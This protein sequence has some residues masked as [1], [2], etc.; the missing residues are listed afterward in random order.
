MVMMVCTKMVIFWIIILVDWW[1]I[2]H[3]GRQNKIINLENIIFSN[4]QSAEH[5]NDD[6]CHRVLS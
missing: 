6:S 2:L 4:S 1:E 5:M 3:T